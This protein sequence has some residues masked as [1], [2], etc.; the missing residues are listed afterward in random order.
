LERIEAGGSAQTDNLVR[1][2]RV[3]DLLHGLDPLVPEAVLRPMELLRLQGKPR[4]RAKQ[5]A[6]NT[7]KWSWDEEQ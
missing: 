4:R 3:L 5:R 1:V 2:F 6:A 7:R